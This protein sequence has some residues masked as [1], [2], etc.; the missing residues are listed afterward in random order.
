MEFNEEVLNKMT[1]VEIE[2]N[3]D[4]NED[5]KN[6][7]KGSIAILVD[8]AILIRGLDFTLSPSKGAIEKQIRFGITG[9]E[10]SNS[11]PSAA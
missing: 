1:P 9:R 8:D 2:T 3:E 10:R 6:K 5:D 4:A 7:D 11:L